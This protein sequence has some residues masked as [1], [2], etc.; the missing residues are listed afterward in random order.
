MLNL[1]GFRAKAH[2]IF[3]YNDVMINSR[4]SKYFQG[5]GRNLRQPGN[6]PYKPGKNNELYRKSGANFMF[7][8]VSAS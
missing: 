5:Y 7:L 6:G 8:S 2:Y 3:R 4:I 1:S